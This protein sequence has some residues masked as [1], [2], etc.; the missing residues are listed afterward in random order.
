MTGEVTGSDGPPLYLPAGIACHR[1]AARRPG[2]GLGGGAS[3]AR[4]P[5]P[6]GR[7]LR[8]REPCAGPGFRGGGLRGGVAEAA[9]PAGLAHARR[10][11]LPGPQRRRRGLCGGRLPAPSWRPAG[12]LG[13]GAPA[14]CLGA[15]NRFVRADCAAFPGRQAAV[16]ALAVDAVGL[17]RRGRGVGRG[18]RLYLGRC[19]PR[20]QRARRFQRKPPDLGQPDGFRGLVGRSA[21]RIFPGAAGVLAGVSGGPGAQ[22]PALV[23]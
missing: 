12:G 10:G 20:S 13:G 16:T 5:R 18:C 7:W 14:A 4:H 11:G 1:A 8:G 3:S 19:H 6:P 15:G 23:R 9:E 22:L 2:A 21:T 17:S